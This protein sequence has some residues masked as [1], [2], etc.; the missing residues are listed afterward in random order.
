MLIVLEIANGSFDRK[1][2]MS[3]N[4]TFSN[5]GDKHG[6]SMS[7]HMNCVGMLC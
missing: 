6:L 2:E 5:G 4:G 3:I 7:G 1:V